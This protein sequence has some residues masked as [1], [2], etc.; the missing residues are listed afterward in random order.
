MTRPSR[1]Q[2]EASSGGL[3]MR[4]QLRNAEVTA[5]WCGGDAAPSRRGGAGLGAGSRRAASRAGQPR[6]R[7]RCCSASP[8]GVLAPGRV[9]RTVGDLTAVDGL[10]NDVPLG[11]RVTFAA[12][13]GDSAT[14]VLLARVNG[15][16]VVLRW[17]PAQPGSRAPGRGSA[18]AVSRACACVC[19]PDEWVGRPPVSD[20]TS[21]VTF[22][23]GAATAGLSWP[24]PPRRV[25]A[26]MPGVPDRTPIT[27][28]LHTGVTAVDVL[29]PVGRGQCMLLVGERRSG[30]TALALDTLAAQRDTG[31]ACVYAA[32][33]DDGADS[34]CHEA[35]A[36]HT[37]VLAAP[38]G[39]SPGVSFLALCTS[40]AL[41]EAWRDAGRDALL[42]VDTA[43]PA[44]AFWAAAAALVPAP[45]GGATLSEA[46]LVQLDGMLV[47]ASAAERRRFFS[48]FLQRCARLNADHGGGSLTLLAVLATGQG[49]YAFGSGALA[50]A[51]AEL[52]AARRKLASYAT[53]GEAQKVKLLAALEAK[54]AQAQGQQ[55][56]RAGEAG[57]PPG[58]VSRPV[59]E[60][61]M[62][63]SDGQIFLHRSDAQATHGTQAGW[64]AMSP[65]DSVS[66]IGLEAAAPAL[67]SAG[68]GAARL[69]L[70]QAD[71][72]DSFAA[73][74]AAAMKIQRSVARLRAALSQPPGRPAA[75][76]QQVLILLA[77]RA[78]ACPDTP[79][80][81]L[82]S[83]LHSLH[84]SLLARPDTGEALRS[85]DATG[86]LTAA[87]EATLLAALK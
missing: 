15:Y 48:S 9:V 28:S 86:L 87:G 73:G 43:Q 16:G 11:V 71:D 40:F 20:L 36:P 39:A 44:V 67:R 60:E 52:S 45:E 19:S 56:Q 10:H 81:E 78:G 27:R 82:P 5:G 51:Q 33:G 38:R 32:L 14:G 35:V 49:A 2:S 23:E 17:P 79:L 64:W 63:V 37:L 68:S 59:V 50:A 12:D 34:R 62:S 8:S 18:V 1:Q 76:S 46:D 55:A 31:V 72:A 58:T 61:F 3:V 83:A 70:A 57:C 13:A 53:L 29:T 77:L 75:L 26:D 6:C 84:A 24:Q 69:E 54:V 66:R 41:G 65:R 22:G 74:E 47:S 25:M 42:V 21:L 4:A 80:D 7:V 30:K 85:I